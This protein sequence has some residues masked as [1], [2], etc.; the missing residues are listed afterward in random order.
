VDDDFLSDY[1]QGFVKALPK[2]QSS[3]LK[4]QSPSSKTEFPLNAHTAA[5]ILD[6][7]FTP[8]KE[9]VMSLSTNPPF[10]GGKTEGLAKSSVKRRI[11]RKTEGLGRGPQT[12]MQHMHCMETNLGHG[13]NLASLYTNFCT[14]EFTLGTIWRHSGDKPQ[15]GESIME[16]NYSLETVWRQTRGWRHFGD[17]LP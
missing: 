14:V 15:S 12:Y 7:L 10:Y 4:A 8:F 13:D 3:N 17:K 5:D 11:L 1:L 2:A 9:H 16:T 6:Q